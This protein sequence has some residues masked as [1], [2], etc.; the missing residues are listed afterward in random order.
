MKLHKTN[1][2]GGACCSLNYGAT[3]FAHQG[4]KTRGIV[5][6]KHLLK[7]GLPCPAALYYVHFELEKQ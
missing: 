3:L 1:R 7:D 6:E 5:R 4:E 2:L